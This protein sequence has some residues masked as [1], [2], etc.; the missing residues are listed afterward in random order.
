MYKKI[1]VATDASEY[2]HH[3]F[4]TAVEYAKQ[5]HSEVVLLYVFEQPESYFSFGVGSYDTNVPKGEINKFGKFILDKTMHD[6]DVGQVQVDQKIIEGYPAS[7]V[8]NELKKDPE[9]GLIVMGTRGHSPMGGAIIG[10][11]TQKV[12]ASAPC[13]VLIVK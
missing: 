12:L 1:L 13:P 9:I 6:V 10:S 5:F 4:A 2:S 7:V 3:A 8:L 11:V